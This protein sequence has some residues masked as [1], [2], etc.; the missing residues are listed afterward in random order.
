MCMCA[1]AR[2]EHV[3]ARACLSCLGLS[4]LVDEQA[5]LVRAARRWRALGSVLCRVIILSPPLVSWGPAM[6]VGGVEGSR[7]PWEGLVPTAEPWEW[8]LLPGR[9]AS[10]E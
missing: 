3:P 10:A 1:H 2:R 7:K 8:V 6:Q 9:P 5:W 4:L